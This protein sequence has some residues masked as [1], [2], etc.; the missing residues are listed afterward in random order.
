[1]PPLMR[2][3]PTGQVGVHQEARMGVRGLCT[4]ESTLT[5]YRGGSAAEGCSC[6]GLRGHSWLDQT[7]VGGCRE[8]ILFS[9]T[10]VGVGVGPTLSKH[11]ACKA[12]F[13]FTAIGRVVG[14]GFNAVVFHI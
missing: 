5:A 14:L 12:C 1:M 2:K 11:G 4:A 13:L 9:P 8:S 6:C 3:G 10:C 7:C